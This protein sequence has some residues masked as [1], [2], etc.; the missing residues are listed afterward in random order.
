VGKTDLRGN[1]SDGHW[2]H[3]TLKPNDPYAV[4]V[5]KAALEGRAVASPGT[6]A[7]LIRRSPDG[8]LDY[9]PIAEISVW[10][11]TPQR[12]PANPLSIAMPALKALYAEAGLNFPNL[13]DP[14][15]PQ[16]DATGATGPAAVAPRPVPAQSAT[17]I[18]NMEANDVRAMIA[19]GVAAAMKA[20]KDAEAVEAARAA[21]EQERIDNAV[22]AAIELERKEAAKGRRLPMGEPA[23]TQ[24]HFAD[25]RKYDGLSVDDMALLVSLTDA[26]KRKNGQLEGVTNSAAKALAIKMAEDKTVITR[27]NGEE[28]H[29]GKEAHAALKAAGLD[30]ADVLSAAKADELNYSTQA[31]YGDDWVVAE[32]SNRLWEKIRAQAVIVDKIPS[33]VVPQGAES[34]LIP[35]E[36]DDPTWYKVGQAADNNAT[37]LRPNATVPASKLATDKRS[38]TVAKLGART[39]FTGELVED[40]IIPWVAQLRRQL[41]TS[42]AEILEHIVIDGDTEAGA[43]ANIN[44]IDGTPAGT[45]AYLILNGFRKSCLVTTTAN[46]R[47]AS[48]S[49]AD[50]DFLNTVK[51]MGPAGK[52]AQDKRAV[53]FIL[54]ANT[55]WKA[56]EL[57]SVKSKDVFTNATIENGALTSV[58]GYGVRQSYF[59][60]YESAKL[61]AESSGK[62]D[63]TDSDNTLGAILAVRYDQWLFAYKR[64][65]TIKLAEFIDADTTQIVALTRVGMAQRDTEGAAISYNV[66][67]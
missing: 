58:W 1:K 26:A 62:I 23:P 66:G 8:H 46:S 67:L 4:K 29:L 42:G 65:M 16:T 12:R 57:A 53:E 30:P 45:E 3:A 32:N 44:D 38:V 24:T 52:N 13:T 49:L 17:E 31:G 19:E 55:Y 10:D 54:D 37:T 51:L 64:R 35:L 21:K 39:L 33:I 36:S 47:S 20:E 18:T 7:H 28:V 15:T 43:S 34:V 5:Y 41:E 61:M 60:H 9:W 63:Q 14:A 40:S 59:M 25:T 50:T 11:G 48:A 6:I 27:R 22:K 56:L 2:L